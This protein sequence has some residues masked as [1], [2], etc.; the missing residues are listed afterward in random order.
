MSTKSMLSEI[1]PESWRIRSESFLT[2]LTASA[3]DIEW[4]NY[5]I[6]FFQQPYSTTH[7]FNDTHILMPEN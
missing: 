6:A 4:H 1:F 5:S 7:F 2:I 3:G